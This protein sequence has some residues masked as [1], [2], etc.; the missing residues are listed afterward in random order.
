MSAAPPTAARTLRAL[1]ALGLLISCSPEAARR[2][3][4]RESWELLACTDDGGLLDARVSISNTGVL[5]GQGHVRL[6]RWRGDDSPVNFA[7]VAAPDQSG[8]WPDRDRVRVGP[9]RLSV[10]RRGWTL[11]IHDDEASAVVHLEATGGPAPA[12]TRIAAGGGQWTQ[13]VPLSAASVSGW[14]EAG[15]RGGALGGHGL[16][17]WRGGDG[18]PDW[19]RRSI[20]ILGGPETTIGFEQHGEARM[21]WGRLEG[22]DLV[23]DDAQLAVDTD[24]TL[25]LDLRPAEDIVVRL[26]VRRTGGTTEPH[27]GLSTIERQALRALGGPP[28]RRV[29]LLQ[30]RFEGP[31]TSIRVPGA[32]VEVAA[33]EDLLDVTPRR[34]AQ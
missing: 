22:R 33:P 6:D 25:A 7:R 16:L 19:P 2:P 18:A 24:G 10:E 28:L 5:A 8:V 31:G 26:A 9:D 17:T 21:A 27:A 1:T 34:R 20:H 32:L 23:M 30:A 14:L 12:D 13:S 29:H 4:W 3:T 15:S 11:R